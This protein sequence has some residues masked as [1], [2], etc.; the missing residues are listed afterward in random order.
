MVVVVDTE[1]SATI[2]SA[3]IT[4]CSILGEADPTHPIIDLY[5][6]GADGGS[7]SFRDDVR[8]GG[9]EE[10]DAGDDEDVPKAS[11]T[12]SQ[13]TSTR[14]S[15]NKAAAPKPTPAPAS[16]PVVD[17]LGGLDDDTFSN[18]PT[19]PNPA[20]NK[21]LPSVGTKQAAGFDGIRWFHLYTTYSYTCRR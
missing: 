15:T 10:Y 14:T 9:F 4:V 3:T 5:R 11:S 6:S 20:V 17:L 2:A 16:A 12:Q 7:S 1:D 8:R 21:A 18:P 13:G 19:A